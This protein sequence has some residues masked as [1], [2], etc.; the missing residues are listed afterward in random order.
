M[1]KPSMLDARPAPPVGDLPN[2][3][4]ARVHAEYSLAEIE[5]RVLM[6]GE[7]IRRPRK[8]RPAER[9]ELSRRLAGVVGHCEALRVWLGAGA[10]E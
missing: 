10:P 4:T 1:N 8:L 7:W 9:E 3:T 2:G 5:A 6:A